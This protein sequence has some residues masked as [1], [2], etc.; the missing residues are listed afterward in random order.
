[1]SGLRSAVLQVVATATVAAFIGLG[2]AGP[3]PHRRHR[4]GRL[5][6]DRGR[7]HP[8]GRAGGRARRGLRPRAAPASS[9]RASPAD[10]VSVVAGRIR[11]ASRLRPTGR[12]PTPA[13]PLHL[14]DPLRPFCLTYRNVRSPDRPQHHDEGTTPMKRMTSAVALIAASL[15]G[16]T[17]CGSSDDPL[18]SS[19]PTGSAS[20]SALRRPDRRRWRELLRVHAARRD[21]RRRAE[22]Q[23]HRRHDQAQH[24]LARDLPARARG[25]LGAGVPRVHR[26]PGVQLRQ[27]LHRHRPR[28]GLPAR[29]AGAAQDPRPCSTSR[30]PRTTTRSSSPRRPPTSTT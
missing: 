14:L 11:A 26:R 20:A 6:A 13:R 21:L 18:A 5:P 30:P 22:G 17:A 19:T 27:G 9:R 24:R 29:A 10:A 12:R 25:Q 28:R 3:L 4:P 16:L 15:L 8:R 23:G 7:R 2:R 1:M